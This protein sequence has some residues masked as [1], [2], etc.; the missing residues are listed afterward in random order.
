MNATKHVT[1][2]YDS[3]FGGKNAIIKNRVIRIPNKEPY[4]KSIPTIKTKSY[5][6]FTNR[7]R[8]WGN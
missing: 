4:N 1:N 5:E 8:T 2:P 7:L 3:R 6:T